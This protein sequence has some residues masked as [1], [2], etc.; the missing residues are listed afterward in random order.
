MSRKDQKAIE[1]YKEQHARKMQIVRTMPQSIERN[2]IRNSA[3]NCLR[4]VK[5]LQ[6][7]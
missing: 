5:A 4:I 1:F 2:R 6:N 7:A 3:E